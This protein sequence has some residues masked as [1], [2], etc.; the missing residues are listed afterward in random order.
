MICLTS[1]RHSKRHFRQS[2]RLRISSV[3]AHI[4]AFVLLK[5]CVSS[6][7]DFVKLKDS[8]LSLLSVVYHTDMLYLIVTLVVVVDQ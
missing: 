8:R 5:N 1:L 7:A 6:S 4:L 2:V 3:S